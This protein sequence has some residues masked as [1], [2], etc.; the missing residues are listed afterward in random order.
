[1][2]EEIGELDSLYRR[3]FLN[4]YV[5]GDD[6]MRVSSS[7]YKIRKEEAG[8][9]VDLARLSTPQEARQGGIMGMGVGEL[10]ANVPLDEGFALKHEPAL[11]NK[12]HVLMIGNF[13]KSKC[14]ILAKATRVIIEPE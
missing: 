6:G 11:N 10:P 8:V 13:T 12:A 7:A 1:M 9:S 5:P 3:F 2:T 4:Q 14:K